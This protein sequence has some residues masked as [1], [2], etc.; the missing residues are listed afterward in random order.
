MS[1]T[2]NLNLDARNEKLTNKELWKVFFYSL[3]I[4]SGCSVTK[5]EAPGFTQGMIPVI[6]KYY[7]T[8]EAKEA[9]YTRHTQLFLTEGRMA[10]FCVGV[11]AAMEER[12]AVQEDIDPDSINAIK[13]A[14][15]G[16]LAG[17]GDSIIHGTLRPIMAGIACSLV[18][19]SGYSSPLG[20][21]IFLTIMAVLSVAIRYFG[22]FKGYASGMMLVE[23]MQEG[24]VLDK[25][26]R[27]A[28]I[29]AFIVCGGFISSLVYCSTPITY[30]SGE[31]TIKLQEMLDGLMPNMIP[32]LYTLL[33]YWL[34]NKKKV[35]AVLLMLLTMVLGIILVYCGILG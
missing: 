14:L 3:A 9:A 22:V 28:A 33:M 19:A 8:Q 35:S 26:T 5:Q 17:V 16:P 11:A 32:L 4:E 15:M 24:G 1:E 21:V 34:I 18:T 20:P 12:Y 7:Q 27:Y 25:L 10:A 29:A 13:V 30:T 31:T 2:A 23:N 6:E